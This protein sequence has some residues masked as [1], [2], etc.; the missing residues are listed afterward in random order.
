MYSTPAW[1]SSHLS[2]FIGPFEYGNNIYFIGP[3]KETAIE[4]GASYH[5]T[6]VYKSSDGGQTWSGF[7]T[8][9]VTSLA[10]RGGAHAAA[11]IGSKLWVFRTPATGGATAIWVRSFDLDTEVWSSLDTSGSTTGST[12]TGFTSI[13]A[14]A[15][16]NGTIVVFFQGPTQS[17]MGNARRRV[18]YAIYTPGTGWSSAVPADGVGSTAADADLRA[19]TIGSNDRIHAFITRSD[20]S[21]SFWSATL[22]SQNQLNVVMHLTGME[23]AAAYP[24]GLA[25][26]NGTSYFLPSSF[27][28]PGT[29]ST[30]YYVRVSDDSL[31]PPNSPVISLSN[32]S[33]TDRPIGIIVPVGSGLHALWLSSGNIFHKYTPTQNWSGADT[34][35]NSG[36]IVAISASYLPARN[37]IGYL[38]FDNTDVYYDEINFDQ[39]GVISETLVNSATSTQSKSSSTAAAK[40][41][42]ATSPQ[43]LLQ[44]TAAAKVNSASSP[45]I[46]GQA[47][48]EARVNSVQSVQLLSETIDV[49]PVAPTEETLVNTARSAQGYVAIHRQISGKSEQTIEEEITT[50]PT[51]DALVN[52]AHSMQSLSDE[53]VVAAKQNSATSTQTISERVENAPLQNSAAGLHTISEQVSQIASDS[54]QSTQTLVERPAEQTT[55][56]AQS[57]QSLVE[58]AENAPLQ[59]AGTALH[60]LSERVV[61]APTNSAQSTQSLAE[62]SQTRDTLTNSASSPQS[63]LEQARETTANSAQSTQSAVEQVALVETV[64][65]SAQ[66][67]QSLVERFTEALQNVAASTQTIL[68]AEV[69]APLV[70][71]GVALHS[72]VEVSRT[73]DQ[74]TNSTSSTQTL[75]EVV[76]AAASN[77]AQSTQSLAEASV[78]PETMATEATSVITLMDFN[79]EEILA[80]GRTRIYEGVTQY[81]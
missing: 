29:P 55:N 57:S 78:S 11:L 14:F 6:V 54:A 18:H 71:V 31:G 25:T 43:S 77:S 40:V 50:G 24:T 19:A 62:F 15:R 22:T 72:V 1:W 67:T 2:Q 12:I 32:V 73:A 44:A 21:T 8:G 66:S 52:S 28:P 17:V 27:A 35:L 20:S 26:T 61:E 46:I 34:Q 3:S 79:Y 33:S 65:N 36:D 51:T 63:L 58:R 56:S 60:T 45:Q 41:N 76:V 23:T 53:R 9:N 4:G 59:N 13:Y 70:N 81:A 39:P 68:S 74:L 80:P 16:S 10:A 49:A 47:I 48:A 5:A 7:P 42:S 30:Y 64:V 38:Y 37:S 75:G 69:P